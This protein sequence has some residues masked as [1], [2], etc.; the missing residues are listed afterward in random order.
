MEGCGKAQNLD[1]FAMVSC[2]ILR[3]GPRNM[4]EFSVENWALVMTGRNWDPNLWRIRQVYCICQL[5]ALLSAEIMWLNGV[6]VR[7]L[8]L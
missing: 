1:N 5:A 8:D 2:G 3:T 6:M 7:K 4:A